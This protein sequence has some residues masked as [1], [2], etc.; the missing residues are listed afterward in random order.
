MVKA[1]VGDSVERYWAKKN[2]WYRATVIGKRQG[3]TDA[4]QKQYELKVHFD[5]EKGERNDAWLPMKSKELRPH[6][7]YIDTFESTEGHIED[8]HS[9]S[10]SW[11]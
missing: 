7:A 6:V 4:G 1:V 5:N 9:T 3:T 8:D 10:G 2:V 11:A